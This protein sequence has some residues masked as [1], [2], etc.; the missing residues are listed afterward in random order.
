[1]KYR[2]SLLQGAFP[3][4][5]TLDIYFTDEAVIQCEVLT[6]K[7]LY[8]WWYSTHDQ[9]IVSGTNFV[10]SFS[11]LKIEAYDLI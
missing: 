11:F 9:R 3:N 5:V 7:I 2:H 6:I 4:K 10:H 8:R 1:M